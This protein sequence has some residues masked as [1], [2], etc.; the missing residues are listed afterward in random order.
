MC[1]RTAETASKLLM[2]VLVSSKRLAER[3]RGDIVEDLMLEDL[4]Q[5][6]R[7]LH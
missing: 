1:E 2:I 3:E 5:T 4:L 6:A 7:T